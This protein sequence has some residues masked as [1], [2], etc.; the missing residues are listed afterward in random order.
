MCIALHSSAVA[1]RQ[2]GGAGVRSDAGRERA[3]DEVG[4]PPEAGLGG[5]AIGDG[6]V[7]EAARP[8]AGGEAQ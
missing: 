7:T 6:G 8:R 5:E 3:G 2:G 1:S 4:G